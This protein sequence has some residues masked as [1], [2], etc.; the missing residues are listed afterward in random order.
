MESGEGPEHITRYSIIAWGSKEYIKFKN[1]KAYGSI[2]G[3]FDDPLIP[4]FKLLEKAPYVTSLPGI[5]RG[6]I[7]GY[8][9][10]DMVRYWERLPNITTD[11]DNWPDFEFFIPQNFI[12]YDHAEGKVY[13]YG[14]IPQL[15]SCR[16]IGDIKSKLIEESLNREEYEKAVANALEY[17]RSG[18][19]F[20]VVISRFYKYEINGDPM[21]FYYRLRKTNPSPY[22]FYLKFNE[23]SLIGSSPE[24]LF[25]VKGSI[26]ETY[27][28]AGTRPRGRDVEE[29]LKLEA[30]LINSEKDKAEHLMLVDLARNDLGKV[31]VAGSVKVPELMYIEK[32]SHVQHLVSKVIGILRK[33]SN[34]FDVL[35][36]TFPA[37]TVSGAPKPMAMK[38]I[39]EFENYRRGPYAGAVGFF[40][41]NGDSEFAILI[42]SGFIIHNILRIQA[43][44]GI[45][46]DS[47][48]YLEY[49]ETEHKLK[50][51]KVALGVE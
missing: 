7:I 33:N 37:G 50:A 34:A 14:E 1:G 47:E 16:E 22:M 11:L 20:Q 48:P 29:D 8:F 24:T 35:K 2:L 9:S 44:A 41:K 43:G 17:I 30:E 31:C 10:Y 51:L 45:V 18:Y 36:A 39:E 13:T 40:S 21:K 6:G 28:I 4:L 26:V 49:L 25:R 46:Y 42:R 27:P 5:F 23:R 19:I 3:E 32:Y 15:S 38:I 12:I